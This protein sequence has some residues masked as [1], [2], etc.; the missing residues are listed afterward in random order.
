MYIGHAGTDKCFQQIVSTFYIKNLRRKIRKYVSSC[1]TCQRVKHPNWAANIEPLSHILKK[2]G[3]LTAVDF[4]GPLP[5]G[6]GSFRY[7]LVCL[8]VFT[9]YVALYPLKAATTRSSLK[10]IT[11][12]Y[13]N[14]VVKPETI[15]SDHG[16]QFT[17]PLWK[18]TLQNLG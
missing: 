8:E 14:K 2:P 6:R 11:T 3:E 17:S 18:E 13:I 9:K 16:S 5:T 4:Y 12:H 7:I 10:K 15:L 1:D